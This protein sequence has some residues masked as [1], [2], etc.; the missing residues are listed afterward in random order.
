M[1]Y[2]FWKA[3]DVAFISQDVQP[4]GKSILEGRPNPGIRSQ[5]KAPAVAG[6][7]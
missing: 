4:G 5:E 1:D 7:G 3:N 6:R 2:S